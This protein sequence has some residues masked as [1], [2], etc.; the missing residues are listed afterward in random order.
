MKNYIFKIK[1]QKGHHA[2]MA[3]SNASFFSDAVFLTG[4]YLVIR[5]VW[6]PKVHP[7][8][9]PFTSVCRTDK[10]FIGVLARLQCH[11]Q[12]IALNCRASDRV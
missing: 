5:R 12:K 7:V 10:R 1:V 6:R 11:L 3:W 4:A 9:G 8:M 2:D